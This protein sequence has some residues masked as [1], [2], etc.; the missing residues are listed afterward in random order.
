MGNKD[1][2][3]KSGLLCLRLTKDYNNNTR[4]IL[5]RIEQEEGNTN[6]VKF[7]KR[8]LENNLEIGAFILDTNGKKYYRIYQLDDCDSYKLHCIIDST[9][10][11]IFKPKLDGYPNKNLKWS[12]DECIRF[13]DWKGYYLNADPI[14]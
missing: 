12:I 14:V 10:G 5:S 11:T 4:F 8:E 6:R 1:I 2:L 7:K 3:L 9:D 13:A